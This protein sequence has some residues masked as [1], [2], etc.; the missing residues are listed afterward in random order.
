MTLSNSSAKE[1]SV[2]SS[3]NQRINSHL[4]GCVGGSS[5]MAM[6]EA[7]CKYTLYF[8]FIYFIYRLVEGIKHI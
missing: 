6:S 7:A 1:N 5:V 3:D 2:F 4:I 8:N